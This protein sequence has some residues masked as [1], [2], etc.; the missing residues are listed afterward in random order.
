MSW[1]QVAGSATLMFCP[2]CNV[3]CQVVPQRTA[4]IKKEANQIDIDRKLAEELQRQMN[5]ESEQA[6]QQGYPAARR[7]AARAEN[8]PNEK[9]WWDSISSALGVTEEE[10][11]QRSAEINV[12]RPPGSITPSQRRL[13]HAN[14]D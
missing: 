14:I 7:V 2:I 11:N 1:M 4:P 13:H 10:T 3:V 12:N 6:V 9:S 5:E 8:Q